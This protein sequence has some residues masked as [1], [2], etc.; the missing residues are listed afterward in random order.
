MIGPELFIHCFG[1]TKGLSRAPPLLNAQQQ[2]EL[3]IQKI[4]KDK[5]P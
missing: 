5:L 3:N 2:Q 1:K 4:Q